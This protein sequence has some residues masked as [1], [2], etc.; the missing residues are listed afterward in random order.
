LCWF[1]PCNGSGPWVQADLENGLFSGGNG[2]NPSNAG[3][4]SAF[5]T[6][7]VKNNGTTTYAI[8]GGNADSGGLTTWYSGSLPTTSGYMPMHQEGAIILGVGGDNSNSSAG[9][10]FEGVMTAGYPTDA[11]D[12]NVQTNIVSVGYAAASGGSGATG[13]IVAGDNSAKC[14]DDNNGSGTPGTKVQMWDCDGN[15]AAQNW[16]VNSNGT[17]TIAGG[18]MDITGANS[19]NGTLIELWT[20]NGGANQQWQAQSG[21]L[22]NPATGKCL[23]DPASNTTNGTQLVLW[24]CN[25]GANQHWTLP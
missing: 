8:K 6:A 12:T 11:A 5:V 22:V 16:T 23:D 10:F 7:L 21:E 13:T 3:N 24:T 15:T 25:G 18:C 4:K 14:V 19:A 9:S 1:G 20:C 2:N 17:L